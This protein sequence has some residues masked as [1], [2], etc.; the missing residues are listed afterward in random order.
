MNL[1]VWMIVIVLLSAMILFF[2]A[3][4]KKKEQQTI[5]PLINFAAENGSVLSQLD[6]WSNTLIGMENSGVDRLFF[7]RRA[8]GKEFKK[9]ISLSEIQKCRVARIGRTISEG[10]ESYQVTDRIELV[11]TKVE[12]NKPEVA[13]EFFNT[14]Y[15]QLTITDELKLAEKWEALIKESISN[16]K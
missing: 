14:D 5:S 3:R 10:K 11:L 15:D 6:H 8:D 4:M 7:I 1:L 2:R 16:R 9:M 13:L 12:K